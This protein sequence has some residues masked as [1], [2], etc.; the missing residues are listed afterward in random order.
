MTN[1]QAGKQLPVATQVQC[2]FLGFNPWQPY[3][4]YLFNLEVV[5]VT[6]YLF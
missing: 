4:L 1:G 6:I 3:S 2:P 5:V